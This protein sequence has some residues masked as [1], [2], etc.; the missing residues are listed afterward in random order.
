MRELLKAHSDLETRLMEQYGVS[1]NEAMALC[2]IGGDTLT[3]SVISEN[4]G[5]S[6]SH[7]SKVIRSI[8]EKELIVRNLGDKDKRQMH[9][10]L[11]DKGRECLE[12]LK[13]IKA[14]YA[15]ANVV[16]CSAMGQEAMVIEAIKSGAKDFIV[17]PFKPDRVLKTVTTIVG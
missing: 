7:T 9:F 15:D 11:S 17:K 2:C 12:A 14:K 5:L 3:A 16:M 13:A 8:E 4:T 10:T 6:A 1:L